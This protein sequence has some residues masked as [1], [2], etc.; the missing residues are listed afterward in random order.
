MA[1]RRSGSR[2]R[3]RSGPG[4]GV[5]STARRA[6]RLPPVRLVIRRS[7]YAIIRSP[8][9]PIA[10][11][12][13]APREDRRHWSPSRFPIAARAFLQHASNFKAAR[14][15]RAAR[16]KALTEK[17]KMSLVPAAVRFDDPRFVYVCERRK[18]RRE[19]IFATGKGGKRGQRRPWRNE[20]SE[21]RCS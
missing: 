1:R 9:R 10:R 2:S 12:A 14:V 19:V 4:R 13:L 16:G 6:N 7:P 3:R 15:G 8:D 5:R 17:A 21:I 18:R 11:L 20:F